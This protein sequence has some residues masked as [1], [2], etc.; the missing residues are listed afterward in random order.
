[1]NKREFL[2]LRPWHGKW[3]SR[4]VTV[5]FSSVFFP[6]WIASQDREKSKLEV[7]FPFISLGEILIFPDKG[8]E[9]KGKPI[10]FYF[11]SLQSRAYMFW[12]PTPDE[13]VQILIGDKKNWHFILSTSIFSRIEII[14]KFFVVLS[15][16]V[17]GRVD[18]PCTLKLTWVVRLKSEC[19]TLNVYSVWSEFKHTYHIS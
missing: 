3:R 12:S 17:G 11:S 10:R 15:K 16:K 13:Q 4:K 6:L 5:I 9:S 7:Q 1:M 8:G 14:Q 19:G 18:M 2:T